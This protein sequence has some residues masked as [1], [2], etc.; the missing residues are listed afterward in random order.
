[1]TD[2]L[3]FATQEHIMAE[4][5]DRL[6]DLRPSPDLRLDFNFWNGKFYE[7]DQS[8]GGH[9]HLTT[10]ATLHNA[11]G[12]PGAMASELME[13]IHQAVRRFEEKR[14]FRIGTRVTP[15][16]GGG[17]KSRITHL[18]HEVGTAMLESGKVVRLK[19]VTTV[20]Y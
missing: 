2:P 4:H 18:D 12:G 16:K 14:N 17:W 15:T 10:G 7:M 20:E 6:G 1:M 3:Q 19:Q 5:D 8:N 9:H 11:N 13:E